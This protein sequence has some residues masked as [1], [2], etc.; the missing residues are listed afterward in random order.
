[1]I[2]F[3]PHP[4]ADLG[5]DTYIQ[6]FQRKASGRSI[7]D[8]QYMPNCSHAVLPSVRAIP[9]TLGVTHPLSYP[10]IP[11]HYSPSRRPGPHCGAA[12]VV[13]PAAG[14]AAGPRGA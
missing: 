14:A 10:T 9:Q 1:M 7:H 6:A 13:R 5:G 3:G 4:E 11:K 2:Y 8:H 12:P